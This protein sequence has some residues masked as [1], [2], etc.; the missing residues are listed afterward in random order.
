MSLLTLAP[1]PSWQNLLKAFFYRSADDEKLTLPWRHIDDKAFLFSRSAW[2]LLAIA[3]CRKQFS[4]KPDLNVW[5]PDFFCNESLLPVREIGVNLVFYPVTREMTPNLVVCELFAKK[6]PPDIF[7]LVDYFGQPVDSESI[8]TFCKNYK[9]WIVEDATHVL[10]PIQ[11]INPVANVADCVIYS[12]HKHLPIPDGA[13]LVIKK[14]GPSKLLENEQIMIIFNKAISDLIIKQDNARFAP[15]LWLVKRIIQRLGL[16]IN[17]SKKIFN[18]IVREPGIQLLGSPRMHNIS[19]SILTH[20][21]DK[22][23]Q[24]AELRKKNAKKWLNV[25]KLAVNVP[26]FLPGKVDA[27]PYLAGFFSSQTSDAESLFNLYQQCGFPL[28]IWPNLPPEVLKNEDMYK[29]AIELKSNRFYLPVHQT[30][31]EFELF[32]CG[33]NVLQK[34][35]QNWHAKLLSYDEWKTYWKICP[36]NN[37]LQSW[38]YGEAKE[39]SG[40][41][42]SQ[43]FLILD[44]FEHPIAIAQ[45]LTKTFSIFGAIARLNR[46]PLLLDNYIDDADVPIRLAVLN[47]LIKEARLQRW[48]IF[49]IAPEIKDCEIARYTLRAFGL[50]LQN[51]H[52]WASGLID[53]NLSEDE[54]YVNLNRRWKRAIR[55]SSEFGVIIENEKLTISKLNEILKSYKNLQES[56][57]FKG[58]DEELVRKIFAI[59]S[60]DLSINLFVAKKI[61]ENGLFDDIGYR[62]TIYCGY[63]ALDFI[64]STNNAGLKMDANSGLYWHAILHAKKNGCRWFDIGG[65]NESTPRGIAEFKNG[66]NSNPY[67][68]VGEW[69]KWF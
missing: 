3:S 19:K 69:R 58:I 15:Y 23:D 46:G 50:K 39:K 20:L 61:N 45:I 43:R 51:I 48:W 31:P 6:T 16:H 4:N 13:V 49:Q 8:M 32:E 25:M 37:L 41:W 65:L 33:R 7:L 10:Q 24:I 68:L 66:L 29:H 17:L 59:Q 44:Q 54:L 5:I 38:H 63:T 22:L 2:S 42:Q 47:V 18:V 26:E 57:A 9:S 67:K 21:L 53:L 60:T 1:L 11:S 62:L 30:L 28:T 27:T 64:V 35:T 40:R 52:P 55:K 36:E 14:N 56:N 12:P 34:T